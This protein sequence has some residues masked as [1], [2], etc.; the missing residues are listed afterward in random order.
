M[1]AIAS[2]HLHQ[3]ATSLR[4]RETEVQQLD[5]VVGFDAFVDEMIEVVETRHSPESYSSI[6][7][8]GD[9]GS[10]AS[11][12][13]GLSACREHIKKM[14]TEG[15]CAVN[16]GDGLATMGF[17]LTSFVTM[18][19]QINPVFEP[20]KAK[21]KALHNFDVE[22]GH[23]IALEFTD[24]K[25]MLPSFAHFGRFNPEYLKEK[26]ADGAFEAACREANAISFV[27]WS[28]FQNMTE[29]WRFLQKEIMNGLSH[30]PH[31]YLDLV[32]PVSRSRADVEDM[33]DALTGWEQIG[34]VSLSL[35]GNEANHL[36]EVLGFETVTKEDSALQA[37]AAQLREKLALSEVGIHLVKSA[38]IATSE[39]SV[40]IDG[41]YCAKPKKSTGA[42]DR[43]NSGYMAGLAL[44]LS[45]A[46]RLTLGVCCSGFFVREA[47]SA[48]WSDVCAFMDTWADE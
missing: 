40:T 27:N 10:W 7:T 41:P 25:I 24:G 43:Y 46:D 8:I 28:L 21:C 22:A 44:D 20:F 30:R 3:L 5:M 16:L 32:D 1:A 36:A 4:Q 2:D 31:I 35:N 48:T 6:Q 26:F 13:A 12:V 47:T 18:G 17:P 14:V 15:G 38:T 19:N 34:R 45:P 11:S 29:N 42:G 39:A 23:T 33:L 9:F 37:L